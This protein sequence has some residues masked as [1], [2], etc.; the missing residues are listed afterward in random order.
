MSFLLFFLF[1]FVIVYDFWFFFLVVS[2]LLVWVFWVWALW[3]WIFYDSVFLACVN[4]LWE[5]WY[6][7]DLFLYY[8]ATGFFITMQTTIGVSTSSLIC[9]AHADQLC[10]IFLNPLPPSW[11]NTMKVFS[12]L[13]CYLTKLLPQRKM[14]LAPRRSCT[15]LCAGLCTCFM[16][17]LEPTFA[18]AL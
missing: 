12:I 5:I 3:I 15:C 17:A 6:F 18:S 4:K 16:P 13:P 11:Y 10:R 7:F 2:V 9:F 1:S 14:V 8:F